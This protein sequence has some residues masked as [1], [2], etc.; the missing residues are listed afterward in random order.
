[1]N[2]IL[3]INKPSGMTS[4]DVVNIV[5]K[6]LNISKV[7]HT[8][9]LDPLATG[10]LVLAVGKATKI[11]ELLT[12][13]E[14]EYVAEVQLGLSTDTLDVTGNVLE[15]QSVPSNIMSKVEKVLPQFL[16]TYE[17]EVPLYSAVRVN[18]KRLYQYARENQEVTLPK[19]NVTIKKIELLNKKEDIFTFSCLVSKGTYI[20]SLIRDIGEKIDVPCCMKSLQRTKQGIFTIDKAYT[21]ENIEKGNYKFISLENALTN[22]PKVVIEKDDIKKVQNGVQLP[23]RFEG[24]LGLLVDEDNNLLAIYQESDKDSSIMRPWKVFS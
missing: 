21:I 15:N 7:G 17:Q 5:S 16:G 12:N 23:K 13:D 9:T 2:G 22:Y 24:K 10:V 6:T 18:G 1:M 20:R 4:R 8:G 11:I 19:R 14:K 3:V